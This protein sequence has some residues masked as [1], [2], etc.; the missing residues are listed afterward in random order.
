MLNRTFTPFWVGTF[1]QQEDA[2][3][4]SAIDRKIELIVLVT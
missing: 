2:V 3:E 1:R 4:L